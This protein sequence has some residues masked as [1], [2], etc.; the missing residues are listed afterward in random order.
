MRFALF[1]FN[2]NERKI[3]FGINFN[4][5]LDYDVE[6]DY[7]A[8][9]SASELLFDSQSSSVVSGKLDAFAH[10]TSYSLNPPSSYYSKPIAPIG[11]PKKFSPGSKG[12]DSNRNYDG[13]LLNFYS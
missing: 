10:T 5:F 9:V 2:Q 12:K 7:N 11:P 8:L 13:V 6:D 1:C 4:E 3:F